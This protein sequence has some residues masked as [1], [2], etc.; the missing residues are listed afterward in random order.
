MTPKPK[1]AELIAVRV[2]REQQW[3]YARR[4]EHLSYRA[5]RQA[6]NL[7]VEQGGLG[8]DLSEHA[9]KG[10]VAGYLAD[11]RDVLAADREE[12]LARQQADLDELA[13][14]ARASLRRAAEVKALDV[15][16]AKLLL[17]TLASERRLHGLDAPTEQRIDVTVTDATDKAI[18]ELAADLERMA[19]K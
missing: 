17:D 9:L 2:L 12:L 16:A 19:K 11:Q 4:L 14:A 10:L 8:Y 3:A 15:H 1:H 6:A 5:M 7:P 13:R 18:A